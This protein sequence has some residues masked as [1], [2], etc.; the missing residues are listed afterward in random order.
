MKSDHDVDA[1][2][3][4]VITKFAKKKRI[5]ELTDELILITYHCRFY[6]FLS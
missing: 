6:T 3:D 1:F 4:K 5:I 2:Y